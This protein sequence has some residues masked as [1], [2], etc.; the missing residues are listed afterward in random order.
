IV[1]IMEERGSEERGLQRESKAL[2]NHI[3]FCIYL[4]VEIDFGLF[5][6]NRI[7]VSTIFDFIWWFCWV[8]Y[9]YRK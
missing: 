6:E 3:C 4:E 7:V 5:Y 9:L 1:N 2:E 8:L